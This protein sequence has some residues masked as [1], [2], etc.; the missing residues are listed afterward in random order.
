MN[1]NEGIIH[2]KKK[3]VGFTWTSEKRTR[4]NLTIGDD[5]ENL[6]NNQQLFLVDDHFLQGWYCKEK[7]DASHY[8]V[9]KG[10]VK[11]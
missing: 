7:L 10:S 5:K 4:W 6:F 1:V 3:H 2:P 8:L 11:I 9:L